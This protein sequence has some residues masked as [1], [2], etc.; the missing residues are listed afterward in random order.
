MS[1]SCGLSGARFGNA[2]ARRTCVPENC[3]SE[4]A[5]SENQ[6]RPLQNL[7][8]YLPMSLSPLLQTGRVR[9]SGQT[10][11]KFIAVLTHV[12]FPAA[13]NWQNRRIR[14]DPC[15]IYRCTYPCRF[16]RCSKLAESE[17]QAR[18][19]QNLSLYLP[20]SLSPLLQT[21]RI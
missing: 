8:L 12:A 7:S 5:E 21:G 2:F 9:E 4:L 20:M 14:P 6:A 16:P 3:C 11:A 10:L 15:K 18:P 19:L 17:N 1:L 13:P